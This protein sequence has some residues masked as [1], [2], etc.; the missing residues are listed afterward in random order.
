MIERN[1]ANTVPLEG[2]SPFELRTE[3]SRNVPE[4]IVSSAL[5]TGDIGFLHSFTTGSAVDGP[6]IRLVAWTAGCQFRCLYCHNPDT[7]NMMNG[8]AVPLDRAIA[9]LN[10]YRHGLKI[11]QGGFTLSGG[12]PLMQDRFAVKLLTAARE[13]GIHTALD[14]NG[15]LG[16][17]L[18][19]AELEQID[20]VLLDI[21]AWDPER[22]KHLTT[23][24]VGPTLD[25]ARRLGARQRP[26][27]LRYVLVPDLT[28]DEEDI[29][30]IAAFAASLGNVERVDVLPFHQMGR[31]KWEKLGIEYTLKNTQPPTTA[32][33][34]RVCE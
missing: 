1:A 11:M 16:E 34:R 31:Y 25:F 8:M 12:E 20:L 29:N 17:R 2:S 3:L 30:H 32:L 18:S 4:S 14:T 9:E 24:D 19:D 23:K 7:W 27:W 15:F 21:K 13:M 28:D 26:I 33:V 10:K 22:H 6:G 5:A